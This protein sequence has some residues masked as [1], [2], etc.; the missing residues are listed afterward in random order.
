MLI[1]SKGST[2]TIIQ[3]NNHKRDVNEMSWDAN[4]DGS[5]ANISL[6]VNDN[7]KLAHQDFQL[8]NENIADI[9]TVPSVSGT[10]DERLLQDFPD[11][12]RSESK[13]NYSNKYTKTSSKTRKKRKGGKR[14]RTRK[15]R[16]TSK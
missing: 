8:T 14:R 7:G 1:N 10:L 6:K 11:V 2:R 3:Q 5:V 13:K 12:V 4:Y 15:H 9:F 16:R